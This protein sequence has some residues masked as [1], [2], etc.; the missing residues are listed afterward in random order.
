[1]RPMRLA[2]KAIPAPLLFAALLSAIIAGWA[3]GGPVLDDV[4]C[5]H[6]LIASAA[7]LSRWGP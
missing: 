2:F 4:L 7:C 5:D 1:M 3:F 6:Y